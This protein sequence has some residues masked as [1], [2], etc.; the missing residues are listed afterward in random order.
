MAVEVWQTRTTLL[1][2]HQQATPT[3]AQVHPV[4]FQLA[5]QS[6]QP[7]CL[8]VLIPALKGQQV[9][10]RQLLSALAQAVTP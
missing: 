2:I 8:T 9:Q 7:L 1:A 10:C 6:A 5:L 3:M 4:R